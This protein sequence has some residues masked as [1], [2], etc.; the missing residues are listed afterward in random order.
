[1]QIQTEPT[2]RKENVFDE[3]GQTVETLEI[4]Q[5]NGAPTAEEPAETVDP[6]T[7][8]APAAKYRIGDKEFATQDE[9]LAY[10]QSQVSALSTE[11]QVADAYRQ[12][13]RD[14]MNQPSNALP[15]VTLPTLPTVPAEPALNTE[16]LYT[17]PQAFLDRYG[18]KIKAE[19]LSEIN[20]RDSARAQG[21][22]I[23]REFT[24][25]HPDMADFRTEVETFVD[26]N[27]T[28]VRGIVSTKGR[29]AAHDFIATKLKSHFERYA[30]ALKPKRE[31]P[32]TGGAASPPQKAAGVTPP[33]PPEKLLSFSDQV[34]SIRKRR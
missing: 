3:N 7:A 5:E 27:A 17:N 8:A 26:Q 31:L 15:G 32:N 2:A 20:Q 30:T 34:R 4:A 13:I 23:W 6:K 1:M 22:A 18:A 19:A 9:A 21:D 24:D 14:S 12:G 11:A 16:E 25:R 29:P 28:D 33:A 10:A